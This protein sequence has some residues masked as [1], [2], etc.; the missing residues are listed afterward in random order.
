MTMVPIFV[1]VSSTWTAATDLVRSA[2]DGDLTR[3][4]AVTLLD[5]GATLLQH[6][7]DLAESTPT[8]AD[9]LAAAMALSLVRG[10]RD[11]LESMT[12]DQWASLKGSLRDEEVENPRQEAA[13]T[14]R[15]M[16]GMADR[17]RLMR[18]RANR[19]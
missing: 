2:A 3:E 16:A 19:P 12:D 17:V 14:I 1:L 15:R 11:H 18:A 5:D 13:R 9:D 6:A 4:E 7:V 10:T 8:E